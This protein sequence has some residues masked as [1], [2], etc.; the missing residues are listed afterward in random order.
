MSRSRA[1]RESESNGVEH[2]QAAYAAWRASTLGR[3]TDTLE[4]DLI[5]DLIR[6]TSGLRILEFGC[7]DGELAVELAAR[8]AS[9]V[10]IDASPQAVAAAR[11]RAV[12]EGREGEVRF[13]VARIE[14]LSR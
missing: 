9:V 4:Q 7:G 12:R 2:L 6:P 5:L 11:D 3:V 8:G 13:E 1:T 14:S 10:G